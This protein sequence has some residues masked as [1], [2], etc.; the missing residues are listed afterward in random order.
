VVIAPRY[1]PL[2]V[3]VTG[4]RTVTLG[5]L[6]E[7]RNNNFQ[8]LR[9]FAATCVVYFHCF[10]VTN[11]WTEEPLWRVAH[12]WD[13]GTVGVE[14]FFVI[15]G[16]LVTKSWQQRAHLP[17]F[18]GARLLRIYPALVLAV[19]VTIILGGIS[20]RLTWSEFLSN[21]MTIDF[22][23]H[24]AS[25]WNLRDELPGAFATNPYPRAVN[26]SLW[27]LPVEIRL[28]V[29][30]ALTG[31]T[32]LMVSRRPFLALTMVVL[33][34]AVIWP[35]VLLFAPDDAA[36]G[37]VVPLFA[38]GA[39]IW[40]GRHWIPV[41]LPLALIA[42]IAVSANPAGL[43]RG[44]LFGPLFSYAVIVIAVHPRLQLPVFNR[45]GDYS[46]GIYVYAFPI[47]QTLVERHPGMTPGELFALAM[48]I[49]VAIAMSSWHGIEKPALSLKSK[50]QPGVP[51]EGSL[52][53]AHKSSIAKDR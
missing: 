53:D 19:I 46:Y 41:S 2:D 7:N 3:A 45:L 22:A 39:I 9:L 26:G 35:N 8:L 25:G 52:R 11:H 14:I 30:V 5:A 47:Q 49:V 17:S 37:R 34:V 44:V 29:A 20:S 38:L 27:T 36:I 50:L 32:G 42:L 43:G 1:A 31:L 40:I 23:W 48:P 28:Y 21:P 18:L 51:C 12:D 24:T 4:L 33:T 6:T 13:F 15:S 10:A 16:F